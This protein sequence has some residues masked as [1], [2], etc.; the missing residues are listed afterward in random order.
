MFLFA[1]CGNVSYLQHVH[2]E[3]RT[4]G[5]FVLTME[6]RTPGDKGTRDL[7]PQGLRNPET[8][9]PMQGLRGT[10]K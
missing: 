2:T 3:N 10:R 7:G 6:L 5:T 8:K 9:D 1:I 4:V